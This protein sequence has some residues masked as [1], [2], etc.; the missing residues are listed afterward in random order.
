M[1]LLAFLLYV[2]VTICFMATEISQER[3]W[4]RSTCGAFFAGMFFLVIW[5][6]FI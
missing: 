5:I 3:D 1:I 4:P 6:W 2:L